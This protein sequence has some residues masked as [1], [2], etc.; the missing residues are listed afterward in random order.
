MDLGLERVSRCLADLGNPHNAFPVVC[1]TGTNGK[2][3]LCTFLSKFFEQYNTRRSECI[4]TETQAARAPRICWGVLTSPPLLGPWDTI[5]IDG[6]AISRAEYEERKSILECTVNSFPALTAFEKNVV[7]AVTLFGAH[8]IRVGIIEAGIGHF[9]DATNI[10]PGE[11]LITAVLTSIAI[12]HTEVLGKTV[13][14]IVGHKIRLARCGR[15][16]FVS[17]QSSDSL[18]RTIAKMYRD[19]G[20][21]P[22]YRVEKICRVL[23]D[24]DGL[25]YRVQGFHGE[26][27]YHIRIEHLSLLGDHQRRANLPTA[28]CVFLYVIVVHLNEKGQAQAIR[29]IADA[30]R[31]IRLPGRLERLHNVSDI[32]RGIRKTLPLLRDTERP[33]NVSIILDGAHNVSGVCELTRYAEKIRSPGLRICWI[34][35]ITDRK[36]TQGILSQIGRCLCKREGMGERIYF[37]G[38]KGPV[39]MEWVRCTPP[40]ELANAFTGLMDKEAEK[41]DSKTSSSTSRKGISVVEGMSLEEALV[42]CIGKK[43]KKTA[44]I[45]TGSL[46]LVSDIYRL[47]EAARDPA[48]CYRANR[49]A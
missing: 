49:K 13:E 8:K 33:D 18:A 3:S 17:P 15:P 48:H 37:V 19:S 28:I 40:S 43:R 30:C 42:D 20:I 38:F 27:T 1:V 6:R 35:G 39:S 4:A 11:N 47:K 46:Y 9:L 21:G 22:I 44:I 14:H 34:V 41:Q 24:T 23:S 25:T 26:Q 16:V 12:D 32:Y 29:S 10:F 2:G 45:V 31:G 5:H 36:D 7:V